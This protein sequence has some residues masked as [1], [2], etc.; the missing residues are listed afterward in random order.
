MTVMAGYDTGLI[1]GA[2]LMGVIALIMLSSL[3]QSRAGRVFRNGTAWIIIFIVTVAGFGLWD[4]IRS[5]FMPR[6]TAF[7]DEGRVEVPL[8]RDGHYYMTAE[9]NGTPVDFVVDTGASEIVLTKED[10]EKAGLAVDR[11]QFY[12]RASTA[13][14]EVRTAPVRLDSIDIGGILD[15]NVPAFVNEGQM[16]Q[17]LLGM[18]YLHRWDRIEI[19]DGKLILSRN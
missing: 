11:L 19:A 5:D 16:F 7:S 8:S 17:S 15:T 9:V 2:I 3:L 10:A 6:Q 14:G 4:D 18:S 1:L 12:G 13:N